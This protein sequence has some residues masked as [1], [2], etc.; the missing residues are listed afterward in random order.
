MTCLSLPARL[1][2]LSMMLALG[3]A[4]SAQSEIE[5]SAYRGV[6]SAADSTVRFSGH[7]DQIDGDVLI[8]WAGRSNEGSVD[9]GV[10]ITRWTSRGTGWGWG[11]EFIHAKAYADDDSLGALSF[12]RLQLTNGH[13]VLTATMFYRWNDGNSRWTPHVGAGLG[14]TIPYMISS[15]PSGATSGYQFG[16]PAVMVAAGV[17]CALTDSWSVFGEYASA[18]SIN[19]LRF[20]EVGDLRTNLCT[21]ALNMG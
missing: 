14:I 6:Q 3:T 2:I 12:D 18:C 10:R 19:R 5:I 16:G 15:S 21:N 13:N 8:G 20:H 7:P 17:S 9:Y 4:A 1:L 11:G